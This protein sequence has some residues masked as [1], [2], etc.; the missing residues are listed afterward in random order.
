MESNDDEK[1]N[2]KAEDVDCRMQSLGKEQPPTELI[3]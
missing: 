3:K 1:E 2:L